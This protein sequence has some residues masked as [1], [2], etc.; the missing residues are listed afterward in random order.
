MNAWTLA[1]P[2]AAAAGAALLMVVALTPMT[3]RL[4]RALG[5]IDQPGVRKAHHRPIPRVGGLA[6]GAGTLVAGCAVV[7]ALWPLGV[8]S[9][10][11]LRQPIVIAA[12]AL[13]ILAVGFADDAK[14][15]SGRSKLLAIVA[16]S[17]AI[18]GVGLTISQF[19]VS[20]QT[21][22]TFVTVSWLV[23]TLWIVGVTVSVNFID[24][25]DGL[26]SGV[27]AI[28]AALV[29]L[30]GILSGDVVT[31]VMAAAL[32]GALLGFLVFNFNPASVFMGDSG[33]MFIGFFVA[34]L[35]VRAQQS[36]GTMLG[37]ILPAIGLSIPFTDSLFT[38]VRRG[39]LQRRSLFSAENGHIHHQLLQ[40]G[41]SQ[42]HAVILIYL[43][44]LVAVAIGFAAMLST[45]LASIGTLL[46]LLPLLLGF[47]RAAGSL[48]ARELLTAVRRNRANGGQERR[49]Q[50]AFEDLQLAFG[51]AETF[52]QWWELI[53]DTGERL[54]LVSIRLPV[55]NRDGNERTLNWANPNPS[56][57]HERVTASVP[58]AQRRIDQPLQ[59]VIELPSSADTLESVGRRIALFTRLVN[60]FSLQRLDES[61]A[62]KTHR[63]TTAPIGKS[64][65][66]VKGTLTKLMQPADSTDDVAPTVV[67][68]PPPDQNAPLLG[69]DVRVAL[70]HDF[71]Y[72]YAGAERVLE[73]L[74]DLFPE[75]EI[76]SLFDFLPADK[77]GFIR[78]KSVHTSFIQ[79]LPL[80]RRS[81]RHYLP[82]MPLAI[83][84]LDLSNYDVV[85]S[86]SYLVA[87]GVIT[88]PDQL[89]ICY[90]HSPARHAWDLQHVYLKESNLGYGPKA[91]LARA[92]LQYIRN[93]DARSANGVDVFLSNSDFVGRRIRKAY[94]REAETVYPPVA[95]E[96]FAPYDSKHGF[97]VTASRLVPYKRIDLI[98]EA[99]SKMPDRRLIVIGDGPDREKIAKL[100]TPNVKLVG[101]QSFKRLKQYFQFAKA[102]VFAAEEDFG[103]VAVEA[104]ACGTPV[105]AYGHGGATES[106]VDG[107]TGLFFN[108]DT[109]ESVIEAVERFEAIAEWD[110]AAIR[111]NAERFSIDNFRVSMA[112]VVRRE[113]LQFRAMCDSGVTS[114]ADPA[115]VPP[116]MLKLN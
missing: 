19:Q 60:E 41:L 89:H 75:A 16:A 81:H 77:R 26:A 104:Q 39:V 99:F 12:A 110:H 82:L 42:R 9:I 34:V 64:L 92:I 85:I 95:V 2:P 63:R 67:D 8:L 38:F 51:K 37:L 4:G 106:I 21:V 97:Y 17:A 50:N 36:A 87:K 10:N 28:T 24:G 44:T 111:A 79:R 88:R 112:S 114:T 96:D 29:C 94:R 83:E 59:A 40:Q 68:V 6:I 5:L 33:S 100:A 3:K 73:Q 14:D 18:C 74:V 53:C 1:L 49:Y 108:D 70:V 7:A 93:W 58:I 84:Q 13:V 15:L 91:M 80:A 45:G 54:D 102:F 46:L 76:F 103:I 57:E 71:L 43:V 72:T 31:A 47:F 25:L 35:A 69:P 98:V 11:D 56:P 109:P 62:T 115:N 20:S 66:M 32:V 52:G 78:N 27:V 101:H 22:L 113:W 23:T 107:E 55:I 48:K 61:A 105:I 86:S 90:C 65:R 30:A 116:A